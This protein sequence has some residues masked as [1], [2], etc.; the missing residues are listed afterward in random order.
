MKRII[1]M[2][3]LF[4]GLVVAGFVI[5][6]IVTSTMKNEINDIN[7]NSNLDFQLAD[8]IDNYTIKEFEKEEGFG[9]YAL[10]NKNKLTRYSVG[11]FPDCLDDY[12]IVGFET[13]ETKYDI[14]GISV[15]D[16]FDKVVPVLEA[17]SYNKE[18][19]NSNDYVMVFI[20]GKVR[21][22]IFLNGSVIVKLAIL[23][24]VTNKEN[25]QF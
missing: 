24:N 12:K 25:V 6:S 22:H 16:T 14:Y 18:E 21:I 20:N 9:G 19:E 5:Y 10:V 2:V 11:G 7:K 15:G 17:H 8:D 4:C 13:E 23:L 1:L 3:I